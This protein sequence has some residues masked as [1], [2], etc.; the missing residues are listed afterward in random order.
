L[1]VT[2]IG[3]AGS[4]AKISSQKTAA[5]E[6]VQSSDHSLFSV[7]LTSQNST[8]NTGSGTVDAKDS[9]PQNPDSQ[10][11]E[12]YDKYQYKDNTVE[13]VKETTVS[14]KAEELSDETMQL[15]S[16]IIAAVS[17]D[18]DV[19]GDDVV[20]ALETLGIT[21]LDLQNPQNLAELVKTVTGVTDDAQILLNADFKQ[22]LNDVSDLIRSFADDNEMDAQIFSDFAAE[23]AKMLTVETEPTQVETDEP[24]TVT[25]QE[26]AVP[27]ELSQVSEEQIPSAAE[28][29]QGAAE[30]TQTVAEQ[31]QVAAEQPQPAVEQTQAA[32][33]EPQPEEVVVEDRRTVKQAEEHTAKNTQT[34]EEEPVS[35]EFVSARTEEKN[36]GKNDSFSSGKQESQDFSQHLSAVINDQ[37]AD[38]AETET[39]AA[40]DIPEYT[41][42]DAQDII[43]QIVEQTKLTLENDTTSIEMQLNPEN[44]GRIFLNIS[45]KEG[46][47]SAQLF[48]QNETVRAALE[49]QIAVLTENL[50]QAGVKVDAI[51][52][53][54]AA[55]EFERNLEQN[56]KGD[57]EQ[58][59]RGEEKKSARRSL[60]MDSLDDLSGLMTEEET[61]VA[62]IM[63]DNGN[64]VDFT[65]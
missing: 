5:S 52:V 43:D 47:V 18:L 61:L 39:A 28:Q 26:N 41:S 32:A 20:K 12:V 1:D 48:A 65:A 8:G 3:Y 7:I 64:S 44:L 55:H 58:G 45:S 16:D 10:N 53:S 23:F 22:I 62:R 15:V 11:M 54:V 27:E 31:P 51:E 46:T 4:A 40:P 33:E 59:K 19:D 42:V 21:A 37:P 29:L 25:V 49:S 2:Q 57:E 6:A 34:G 24:Q 60:R 14:E 56:A 63:K 13:P 38:V 36:S 35:E 17:E 50:N 30:Q 9:T